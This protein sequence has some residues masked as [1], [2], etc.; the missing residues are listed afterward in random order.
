MRLP[1][2]IALVA[3]MLFL[4]LMALLFAVDQYN[5]KQALDKA[6][7]QAELAAEDARL[8]DRLFE[9]DLKLIALEK[10]P[11]AEAYWRSKKTELQNCQAAP[12][13]IQA[14]EPCK[15]LL[16]RFQKVMRKR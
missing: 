14:A 3:L 6:R 10:G 2:K 11:M 9:T 15:S 1:F 4:G 7:V 16:A 13:G 5:E 12:A 8:K